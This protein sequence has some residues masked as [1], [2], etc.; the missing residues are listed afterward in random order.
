ML[1]NLNISS[2]LG[3]KRPRNDKDRMYNRK[4]KR[5]KITT[6]EFENGAETEKIIEEPKPKKQEKEKE[7]V[8]VV[9]LEE[10]KV[11]EEIKDEE[12]MKKVFS[13]TTFKELPII[14]DKLI[15]SLIGL[16]INA[17]LDFIITE[18][19]KG[20]LSKDFSG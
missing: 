20:R 8:K 10:E 12:V 19:F 4:N 14:S 11:P 3:E 13:A 16:N 6:G 7:K 1:A 9:S 15:N 18:L 2:G 17:W 5:P